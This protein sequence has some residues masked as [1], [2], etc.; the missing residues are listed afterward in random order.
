MHRG[1][2]HLE[3]RAQVGRLEGG[4]DGAV[5]QPRQAVSEHNLAT[6]YLTQGRLDNAEPLLRHALATFERSFGPDSS[7]AVNTR[8][9]YHQLRNRMDAEPTAARQ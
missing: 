3:A 9:A 2:S 7:Q 1:R 4:L 8:R 6:I 5:D